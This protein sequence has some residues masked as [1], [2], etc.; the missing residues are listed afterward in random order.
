[1]HS[2]PILRTALNFGALSGLGSF[3]FFLGL[4]FSDMNPLGPISWFGAWIPIL[5]MVL[6]SVFYRNNENNGFL[7]YWVAF[8]IGFVTAT[9]AAMIFGALIWIFVTVIDSTVLDL[10]KQES[11]NALEMTEGMMKNMMGETAFDQSVERIANMDMLDV[12]AS[13]VLNKIL[14]GVLCAF[15][16]A[17]FVRREHHTQAE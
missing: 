15:I 2:P 7:N 17:A 8:R 6:G 5:F 11:L 3:V 13:E 14:G 9:S 10:Y 12:A 1:M 4:Y 16:T